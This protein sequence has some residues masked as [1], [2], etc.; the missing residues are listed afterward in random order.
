MPVAVPHQRFGRQLEFM[1]AQF[2]KTCGIE[3]WTT[4]LASDIGDD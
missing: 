1:Y 3:G 2:D 4:T